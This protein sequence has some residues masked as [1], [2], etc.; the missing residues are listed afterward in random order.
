MG[1]LQTVVWILIACL[2]PAPVDAGR[3]PPVA[4]TRIDQGYALLLQARQTGRESQ[5]APLLDEAVEVFKSAYQTFGQTTK[6]QALIGAAQGYLLMPETGSAWWLPWR[7]TPLHRAEK[8][9]LQALVLFPDN[10]AAELLLGLVYF[11]LAHQEQR[12]RAARLEQ[13]RKYLTRAARGG[14]PVRQRESSTSSRSAAVPDFGVEDTILLLRYLDVRGHGTLHDFVFVYRMRQQH[15]PMYG[16]VVSPTGTFPLVAHPD[17]GALAS[18][19]T[20]VDVGSVSEA[21]GEPGLRFRVGHNG[22]VTEVRFG[23]NG[24][25]FV[26][27]GAQA[28][29]P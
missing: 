3:E 26:Y 11:R 21:G 12:Q 18:G 6:V 29:S 25:A 15:E 22:T 28:V 9:L 19:K 20:L 24:T 2:L 5:R 14:V 17:R 8:S 13:S 27:E 23:W 4:S 10:H 16:V 1:Y 7:A